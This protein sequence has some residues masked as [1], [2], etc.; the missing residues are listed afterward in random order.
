MERTRI[1]KYKE[2]G[3][4]IGNTPLVRYVGKVPNRNTIWIKRECDNPFGSHYDRVYTALF[5]H[6]E[7]NRGLQPGMNVLETTSGTAGVSFAG[8]GRELGYKCYVM[9][10]E[11]PIKQKRIEAIR[12]QG[13]II[14]P[15]PAEEDIQGFT[16][17]RIM[18]NIKRYSAVFL[19][20]SMDPGGI[21]NEITLCSL[22]GIAGEVL[23]ETGI[24]V[25]VGGIGN[26]SS[27]VGPGRVFR[28]RNADALIVGY[29]PKKAGK[30][31]YPGLMNQDGLE[32]TIDFPHIKEANK[33]IDRI[34]LVDDWNKGVINH[35]DLG[36]S[37]K[38]GI[39]VA[40][41]VARDVTGKNI[42]VLGYDKAERY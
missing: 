5:K 6:F 25:F 12:A 33:L 8:I 17:E 35:E 41:D 27:I 11:D 32:R 2:L 34:M 3:A 29:K 10:P 9:I 38:A 1:Q 18:G 7:E 22:A 24:D 42:L 40:L 20:H 14:L 36:R 26:G 37:A 31:E 16:R 13:G 39:G 28:V 19:N 15:T 23:Q 30:S 4:R 21:N